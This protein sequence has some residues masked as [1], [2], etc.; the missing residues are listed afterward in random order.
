M[1]T[2]FKTQAREV[3]VIDSCNPH[4]S[5]TRVSSS[6]G[7]SSVKR[8]GKTASKLSETGTGPKMGAGIRGFFDIESGE[9]NAGA[10]RGY[11]ESAHLRNGVSWLP[12]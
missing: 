10:L 4:D 3:E 9:S 1:F 8:V 5:H 6:Q 12:K 2:V 11:L 7:N